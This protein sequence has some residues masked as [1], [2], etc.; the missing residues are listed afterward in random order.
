MSEPPPQP[1]ASFEIRESRTGHAVRLTLTG[2]LDVSTAP[3]LEQRLTTLQATRSPVSIDLSELDFID[4]TGIGLLVRMV[5]DALVNRWQLQIEPDL[6]PPVKRMI[7]VM[8][9]EYI[10]TGGDNTSV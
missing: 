1:P 5:G 9:L 3:G 6:S 10:V 4:S 2:E 8:G 7:S